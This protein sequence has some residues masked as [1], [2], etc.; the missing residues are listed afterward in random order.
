MKIQPYIND[1]HSKKVRGRHQDSEPVK[2]KHKPEDEEELRKS[3]EKECKSVIKFK[4]DITVQFSGT[5]TL[6]CNLTAQ[7]KQGENGRGIVPQR[8]NINRKN[9]KKI[10]K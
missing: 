6:R 7:F 4:N 1:H 5:R 2:S 3:G 8:P 9:I 10:L